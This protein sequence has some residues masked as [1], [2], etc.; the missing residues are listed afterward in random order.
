M[1][2]LLLA[3]CSVGFL[4]AS[5]F[6]GVAYHWLKPDTHW[7][8]PFCRMGKDTCASI[9]FAPQARIFGVP[10]SVV[11]QLFYLTLATASLTGGLDQSVARLL[12]TT[13]S[14]VAVLLGAYLTYALLVVLRVHCILCYTSHAI[15]VMLLALLV[16]TS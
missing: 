16:A 8:P 1:P 12:L 14:S 4:V 2:W 10:N 11:G 3:L 13:V 7:I 5:Y 9:V 6:T 15:N